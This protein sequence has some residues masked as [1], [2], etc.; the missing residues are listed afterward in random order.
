MYVEVG[1]AVFGT[2]A[3]GKNYELQTLPGY[4]GGHKPAGGEKQTLAE[5]FVL[6]RYPV[7]QGGRGF[8]RYQHLPYLNG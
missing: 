2:F 8:C 5:Y 1:T 3:V 6:T 7:T 4:L